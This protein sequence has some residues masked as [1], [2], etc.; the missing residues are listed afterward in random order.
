MQRSWFRRLAI[1]SLS[2]AAWAC[3]P[4]IPPRPPEHAHY[5]VLIPTSDLGP[6]FM[7]EQHLT[8]QY[9]TQDVKLDCVV[10]LS[11]GKLTV[12]GLTP[13][14]TRAFLIEQVGT[15][16][17]FEQYVQRDMPFEPVHVLYDLHRVF[18]R[19]LRD[20]PGKNGTYQEQDHGDMLRERWDR[21]VLVE[22]RYESLEP[23]V[24]NYLV[25]I[26]YSAE[27][28]AKEGSP[29]E[30]DW[31]IVGCLYTLEPAE[32]PMVP[33]TMMRNALGVEEGGSGVP[34]DRE[35]YR[36]SVAFWSTHA[37]WR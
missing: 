28:L 27:Q 6:P 5:G 9:G 13:F 29:I 16:V 24:A 20:T 23:P 31:G 37:N 14:G 12:L 11:K 1:L 15:D 33:I 10:Q 34:L 32:I 35:A 30:A 26:L 4:K 8:G 17:K 2:C 7:V 22:R 36:R 21:G 18:F 19:H 25:P 3:G